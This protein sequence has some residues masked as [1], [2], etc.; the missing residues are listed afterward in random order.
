M[1]LRACLL[2][3]T[4]G[5][6]SGGC[7]VIADDATPHMRVGA[8]LASSYVHR[9][10]PQNRHGVAQATIDVSLP[11][12]NQQSLSFG[13]FANM[14]LTNSVGQAWFPSGHSGRVTETDL[15]ATY[16]HAFEN[17][18]SVATGIQNYVLPNGE[19][20]PNGPREQTNELFAHVQKELLGANV[21]LQ[22]R[23]DVDQ[24]L[25]TYVRLGVEEDFE[26]ADKWTLRL[27]SHLGR[28]SKAQSFWNYGIEAEGLAD[29]EGNAALEYAYDVRTVVGVRLSG[30]TIVDKGI[31]DWF[32]LIAIE[33]QNVWAGV[34]CAWSF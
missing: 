24:A 7:A 8:E 11:T 3:A 20:F 28:S 19:S 29:L 16:A 12:R 15:S 1:R 32:D 17:G 33:H 26:L 18:V 25:G 5:A 27:G 31:R 14:D 22:V 23:H 30:S 6:L 2:L 4:V 10:M 34:Y 13:V 9:G 21:Q